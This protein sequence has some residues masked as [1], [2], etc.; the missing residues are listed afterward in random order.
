[1]HQHALGLA[2][3]NLDG[4]TQQ[5]P[6]RQRVQICV[7]VHLRQHS[8]N[9]YS[10]C[11]SFCI[12]LIFTCLYIWDTSH[13][14]LFSA[15]AFNFFTSVRREEFPSHAS[16]NTFSLESNQLMSD[17]GGLLWQKRFSNIPCN[18]SCISNSCIQHKSSYSTIM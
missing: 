9:L 7:S 10:L 4:Q 1:M 5:T 6:L 12:Y 15:A 2:S 8:Q 17:V 11:C 18:I 16:V 14:E 13:K 3:Q